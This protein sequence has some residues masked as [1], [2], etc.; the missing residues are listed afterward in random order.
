MGKKIM[1][2]TVVGFVVLFIMGYL[3]W[4]L[5]LSSMM[6]EGMAAAGDCAVQPGMG[7]LAVVHVLL[8]LLLTLILNGLKVATAKAGLIAGAWISL[9]MALYVGLWWLGTTP[10]YETM[11]MVIDTG[12]SLVQ[13]AVGGAAIGWV[14]GKVS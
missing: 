11:N 3:I 14:L 10:Y 4:G 8:A 9:I 13:G 5:L 2:G 6:E 1:A 7:I 12:G